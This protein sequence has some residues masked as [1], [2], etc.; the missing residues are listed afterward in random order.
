MRRLTFLRGGQFKEKNLDCFTKSA[1]WADS[2]YS[3]NLCPL[4]LS[5]SNVIYFEASHW[6]SYYMISSR[7]LIGQPYLP[8]T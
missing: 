2:V 4:L 7:P 1:H 3:C 8:I 6:S 5:P